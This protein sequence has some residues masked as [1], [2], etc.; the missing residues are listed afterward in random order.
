MFCFY[1]AELAVSLVFRFYSAELA[2]PRV[3]SSHSAELTVLM[4]DDFSPC[5]GLPEFLGSLFVFSYVVLSNAKP[6]DIGHGGVRSH[7]APYVAGRTD[8]DG[9][10][11]QR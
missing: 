3:F 5:L 11:R 8:R 4:S 1:S 6:L 9:D 7:R 10:G 2:V